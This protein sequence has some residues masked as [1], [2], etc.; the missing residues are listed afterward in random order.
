MRIGILKDLSKNLSQEDKQAVEN[1]DFIIWSFINFIAKDAGCPDGIE[2]SAKH[3]LKEME[4]PLWAAK[5][6]E[7]DRQESLNSYERELRERNF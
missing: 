4:L 7:R 2:M 5:E 6:Q 3:L 1:L